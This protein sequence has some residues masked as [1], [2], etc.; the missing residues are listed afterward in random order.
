[1]D[2]WKLLGKDWDGI[3][4]LAAEKYQSWDWTHGHSPEFIVR[5]PLRSNAHNVNAR[6][7]ANRGL[8]KSIYPEETEIS[9][10][11]F[12]SSLVIKPYNQMEIENYLSRPITRPAAWLW[13]DLITAQ[14][15]SGSLRP[16]PARF[17]RLPGWVRR[18]TRR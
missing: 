13:P 2:E 10:T 7:R 9:D 15:W 14:T 3:H 18:P 16:A 6:I 1:M 11:M 4:Q 8:V 17:D 5:Y 12:S